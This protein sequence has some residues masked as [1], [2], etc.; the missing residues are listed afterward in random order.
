MSFLY[1]FC[2][3]DVQLV[4]NKRFYR[5][6]VRWQ[7]RNLTRE[8]TRRFNSSQ[9][10]PLSNKKHK[11]FSFSPKIAKINVYWFFPPNGV[12]NLKGTCGVNHTNYL[13]H[14][15]SIFSTLY[16]LIEICVFSLAFYSSIVNEWWIQRTRC[17]P[18]Q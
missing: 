6:R 18:Q 7:T 9:V 3:P 10:V 4:L 16:A 5:W 11:I 14:Y 15:F 13:L 1:C 2:S 17:I 12:A 8:N